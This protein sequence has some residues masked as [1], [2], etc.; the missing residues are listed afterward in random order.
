[1]KKNGR[2]TKQNKKLLEAKQ[3]K[4]CREQTPDCETE[5]LGS[6][7]AMSPAYSGLPVLGWAAIRD[8]TLLWLS[9]EG[10]QRRIET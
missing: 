1:M 6:R 3:S 10:R 4:K 5:V 9:S 8:S 2:E 7:P